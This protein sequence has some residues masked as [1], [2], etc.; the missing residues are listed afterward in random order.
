MK[1]QFLSYKDLE[2]NLLKEYLAQHGFNRKK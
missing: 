2:A 1:P